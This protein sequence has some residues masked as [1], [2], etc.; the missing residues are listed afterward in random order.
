MQKTQSPGLAI[1]LTQRSVECMPAFYAIYIER[2]RNP[3]D[4]ASHIAHIIQAL[5]AAIWH[6]L[7]AVLYEVHQLKPRH[8]GK[9][10]EQRMK[11]I[12]SR[13]QCTHMEETKKN[14]APHYPWGLWR[15]QR[16][17]VSIIL[18]ADTPAPQL[19]IHAI[20]GINVPSCLYV[21]MW[22]GCCLCVCVSVFSSSF[23]SCIIIDMVRIYNMQIHK[24]THILQAY[25][26]KKKM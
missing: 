18:Y 14:C 20:F 2:E 4:G 11:K 21:W 16:T 9:C 7:C 24:Y 6:M 5:N 8:I 15:V 17:E 25:E 3:F 13:M 26:H 22:I 23:K 19:H 1:W 10:N 12:I